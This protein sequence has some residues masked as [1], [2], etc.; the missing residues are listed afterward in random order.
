MNINIY[1]LIIF[2]GIIQGIIFGI[3]V[4][5]S[6]QYKSKTNRYLALTII[7]LSLS[8]LNYWFWD[9]KIG[10]IY[11]ITDILY[12]PFQL[13]FPACFLIYVLSYVDELKRKNNLSIFIWF[14]PF[15]VS[16]IIHMF[17]KF[18]NYVLFIKFIDDIEI[19][20]YILEE[21]F[22]VIFSIFCCIYAYWIIVNK[23]DEKGNIKWL[24][25]LL[26]V[27]FG[28]CLVWLVTTFLSFNTNIKVSYYPLWIL[29]SFLFYWL[30]Y[31]SVFNLK[32]ADIVSKNRKS[33]KANFYFSKLQEIIVEKKA[34]LNPELSLYSV[35]IEIE[36]SAGYLSQIINEEEKK[37][38]SEYVNSM[39]VNEVIIMF[40][41]PEYSNYD[42]T[43]IGLEAGFNS[44]SNFFRVFK[45]LTGFTPNQY[46]KLK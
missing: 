11:F 10:E 42:I 16:A 13:V 30:A 45:K 19:S 23:N 32:L 5:F 24:V 44:K 27:E 22:S 35:A 20:F 29:I 25:T 40:E 7:A 18:N 37:S 41:N 6:K 2:A 1:N 15:I 9:T 38:F 14:I 21:Y 3:I 17:I 8:N 39:R 26:R 28:L 34:F 12:F 33:K 4:L 46:K 36:I 43:A 31:Q